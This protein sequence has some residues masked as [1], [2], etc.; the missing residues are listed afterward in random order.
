MV[1]VC[2]CVWQRGNREWTCEHQTPDSSLG[3]FFSLKVEVG[4]EP[5]AQHI[6]VILQSP[7]QA[8]RNV[9][10]LW[11]EPS[12]PTPPH[13]LPSQSESRGSFYYKHNSHKRVA[14]SSLG[15]SEVR[16]WILLCRKTLNLPFTVLGG[17]WVQHAEAAGAP[18][19]PFRP[20][21]NNSIQQQIF[22]NIKAFKNL[23]AFLSDHIFNQNE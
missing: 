17:D 6:P 1:W 4:S 12:P 5:R 8:D 10:H 3:F 18:F 22:F 9:N 14:L 16:S 15:A 20:T 2:V 13:T 19:W 11:A 21:T 7:T 23:P